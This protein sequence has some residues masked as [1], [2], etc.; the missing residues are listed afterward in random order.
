M[1]ISV[2]P[3]DTYEEVEL[4]KVLPSAEG[5][6]LELQRVLDGYR[7]MS[8]ERL[9]TAA[10]WVKVVIQG[11]SD[12]SKAQVIFRRV[13]DEL[14][15]SY[16]WMPYSKG[17]ACLRMLDLIHEFRPVAG[18]SRV[19]GFLRDWGASNLDVENAHE[20][21][22]DLHMLA[23]RILEEYFATPRD[24]SSEYSAY[25]QWLRSEARDARY[26][27]YALARL[28]QLNEIEPEEFALMTDRAVLGFEARVRGFIGRPR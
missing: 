15:G 8:L 28:Q 21:I 16:S 6:H 27:D 24:E 10:Q 17:L 5:W 2:R 19:L 7:E 25:V 11:S 3:E 20:R 12:L 22:V 1:A 18:A 9:G 14:V 23:L 26:R 13:L 4:L